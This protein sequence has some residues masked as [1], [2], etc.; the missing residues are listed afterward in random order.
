MPDLRNTAGI[1]PFT[2]GRFIGKFAGVPCPDSF[3]TCYIPPLKLVNLQKTGLEN[4]ETSSAI[5]SGA[6]LYQLFYQAFVPGMSDHRAILNH[7]Q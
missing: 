2:S 6:D 5:C 1:H 3:D 7:P 4:S